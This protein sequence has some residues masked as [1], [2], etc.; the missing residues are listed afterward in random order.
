MRIFDV[1][2]A[3]APARCRA[4]TDHRAHAERAMTKNDEPAS[5]RVLMGTE[6]NLRLAKPPLKGNVNL[7]R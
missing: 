3:P 7:R 4:S 2:L 1:S 6:W 5:M